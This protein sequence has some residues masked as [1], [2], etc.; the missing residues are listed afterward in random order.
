MSGAKEQEDGTVLDTLSKSPASG[1]GT[2]QFEDRPTLAKSSRNIVKLIEAQYLSSQAIEELKAS[3]VATTLLQEA[4]R[5]AGLHYYQPTQ[6]QID[7]LVQLLDH[8]GDGVISS[9]D[10]EVKVDYFLKGCP[11][12]QDNYNSGASRSQKSSGNLFAQGN[13]ERA[14]LRKSLNEKFPRG[15]ENLVSTC[16]AIFDRYDQSRDNTVEYDQLLPMLTD[17]Y[18]LF[19]MNFKPTPQDSRRYIEVIDADRDGAISWADFE[20]FLLR[21]L[22]SLEN[23]TS[24]PGETQAKSSSIN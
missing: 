1:R 7:T 22:D 13:N 24:L 21:V 11:A 20:L 17:V 12:S 14:I 4:M 5:L 18:S 15:I 8:N 2:N 9:R 23:V 6:K 10:L 16:K 3:D 19:G